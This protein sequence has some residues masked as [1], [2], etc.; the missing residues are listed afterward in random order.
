MSVAAY[1]QDGCFWKIG[2]RVVE[3]AVLRFPFNLYLRA[4]FI[5]LT[6][7]IHNPFRLNCDT[8]FMINKNLVICPKES[9]IQCQNDIEIK[10][11]KFMIAFDFQNFV[12][13]FEV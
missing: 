11:I 7:V 13:F 9:F 8:I 12:E 3:A 10:S 2:K 6:K 4:A 5:F 1:Y